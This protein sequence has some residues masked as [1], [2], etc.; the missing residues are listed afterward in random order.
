MCPVLSH[1]Y[2]QKWVGN[3]RVFRLKTLGHAGCTTDRWTV[4]EQTSVGAGEFLRRRNATATATAVN[5]FCRPAHWCNRR[6][7]LS[8]SPPIL[9]LK[10]LDQ[11][12]NDLIVI[13]T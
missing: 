12:Y 4:G 6:G 13:L 7:E 5:E 10:R 8:V 1:L 3:N 11:K 9:V 2:P